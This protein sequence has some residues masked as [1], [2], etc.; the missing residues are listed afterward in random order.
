MAKPKPPML[1]ASLPLLR[2]VGDDGLVVCADDLVAAGM[3]VEGGWATAED[4]NEGPRLRLTSEGRR[5]SR[6]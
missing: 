3:A 4:D 2:R 1:V 6:S 5:V